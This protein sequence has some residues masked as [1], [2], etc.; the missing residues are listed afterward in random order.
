MVHTDASSDVDWLD[1]EAGP[2]FWLLTCLD[3][4]PSKVSP[5]Q[6]ILSRRLDRRYLSAPSHA[7]WWCLWADFTAGSS[8]HSEFPPVF[9]SWAPAVKQINLPGHRGCLFPPLTRLLMLSFCLS[10]GARLCVGVSCESL[11]MGEWHF[12]GFHLE[13]GWCMID[14]TPG[15]WRGK[16]EYISLR[17][18]AVVSR[19]R[20]DPNRHIHFNNSNVC[21]SLG[22]LLKKNRHWF[23]EQLPWRWTNYKNVKC[24]P[25]SAFQLR[26]HSCLLIL[27]IYITAL[28]CNLINVHRIARHANSSN[29]LFIVCVL[30][31]GSRE[32]SNL[33]GDKG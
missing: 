29:S 32:L 22:I 25:S 13:L 16:W 18:L 24:T 5:P 15:K 6:L 31:G 23:S 1:P 9:C 27:I 26:S 11:T 14:L 10:A 2:T 8:V 30:G 3:G 33:Y 19:G 4:F 17:Q 20:K 7:A 28:W 21:I 12:D